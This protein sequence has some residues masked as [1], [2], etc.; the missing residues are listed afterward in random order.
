MDE[1]YYYV[2]LLVKKVESIGEL[3]KHIWS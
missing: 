3:K 2:K 1:D